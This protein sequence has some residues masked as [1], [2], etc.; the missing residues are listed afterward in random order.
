MKYRHSDKYK[1]ARLKYRSTPEAK[2]RKFRLNIKGLYGISPERYDQMLAEQNGV[3]ALC[4]GVGNS[5][6]RLSVDHCHKTGKIRGLLCNLCNMFLGGCKD[7]VA[8]LREAIK[9]IEYH[10]GH[11]IILDTKV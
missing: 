1:E 6:R 11:E 8:I 10:R 3:C 5:G 2:D 4:L 7:D 9:Y